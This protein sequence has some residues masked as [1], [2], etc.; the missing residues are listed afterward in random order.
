MLHKVTGFVR[1]FGAYKLRDGARQAADI[2]APGTQNGSG[3]TAYT[4]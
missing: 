3:H 1:R 4:P 2:E